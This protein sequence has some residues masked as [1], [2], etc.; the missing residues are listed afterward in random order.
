VTQNRK[1]TPTAAVRPRKPQ[2]EHPPRLCGRA[3]G[4]RAGR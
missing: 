1:E 4:R 3:V 2:P